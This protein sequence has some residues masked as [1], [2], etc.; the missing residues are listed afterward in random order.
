[1]SRDFSND[2]PAL[3]IASLLQGLPGVQAD[4]R[5]N[6]AQDSRISLRGFGSRSSFGVRGIEVLLDGVPW[7]TADGQ[8]Q[9]GSM[10]LS[11]LA[12][13]EV[14]RGPF[15]ALYGNSAGGVLALKSKP[16]SPAAIRFQQLS[17][18][19]LQQQQLQISNGQTELSLQQLKHQGFRQHNSAEKRQASLRQFAEVTENLKLNWRYD[20]SD[21]PLLEDPQ[22]LTQTDWQQDPRQTAA[23][24]TIFN[25]QKNTAQ[26]QLSVQLEPLSGDWQLAGWHG[27]RDIQQLLAFS[28]DAISSAGGVVN[29]NRHFFGVKGQQQ[30]ELGA[31]WLQYSAQF[32]QHT[33]Q[34]KGNVNQRG[35]IG[36]LRRD[37]T[38]QVQST[39]LA[40][41]S[42]YVSASRWRLSAG[43]RL[44]QLKFS[45]T[46]Y[47]IQ[48]G[49]PDDSGQK[50]T[51]QPTFALG[52]S[53]PL[54][55][56][57]SWS[58]NIGQGFESPTLTEMAYQRIGSGL[59]LALKAA[60]N[61]Q[62]ESGIKYQTTAIQA[63]VDLFYIQSSDELVV[64]QSVGGRTSYRNAASSNRHGLELFWQQQFNDSWRHRFSSTLLAS[65]FETQANLNRELPGV[66]PVQHDWLLEYRP[67]QDERWLL[68]SQLSYRG[69]LWVDDANSLSAPAVTLLQLDSRWRLDLSQSQ[70][71]FWLS[72]E[73]A[74][75]KKYVGAV[76]V[77]QAN[78]RSF[79]PG[80][81][82]QWVAGLQLS[83][84]LN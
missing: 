73:N 13:V 43:A 24:A 37:E 68:Q 1:N 14:L 38:G 56:D 34:R 67:W 16:I 51:E 47:F 9:P 66:A 49:N 35:S 11:Q 62:I 23:V 27:Q 52:L 50:T 45:V 72:L 78:G 65:Q 15:A 29:L 58:L 32:E 8:S 75:D 3:D 2:A 10:M 53:Y 7:S 28:G 79:E 80:V 60:R 61:R 39:E 54:R 59:N 25:S 12:G 30:F 55:P 33:D 48:P 26:R 64:D 41:R 42:E 21:D 17:G 76:V 31:W 84:E 83:I 6:F 77:N 63:S 74:F 40:F 18:N 46:D 82:R 20:W 69:K 57:L 22:G 36:D 70:W 81:P 71:Q 4:Q 44:S 19:L 5:A